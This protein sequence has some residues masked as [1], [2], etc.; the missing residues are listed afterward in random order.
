MRMLRLRLRAMLIP[1]VTELMSEFA[2]PSCKV[3]GLKVLYT[4]IHASVVCMQSIFRDSIRMLPFK[5][6]TRDFVPAA[7]RLIPE[8]G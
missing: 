2:L 4:R 6:S 5:L 8:M 3:D 7:S 1:E